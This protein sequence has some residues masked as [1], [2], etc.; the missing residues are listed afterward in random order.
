MGYY[1]EGNGYQI[2][3]I[4]FKLWVPGEPLATETKEDQTETTKQEEEG[5][6]N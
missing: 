4:T 3:G 5:K 2:D 1:L 6:Q